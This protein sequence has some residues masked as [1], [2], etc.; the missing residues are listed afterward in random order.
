M[1]G[2]RGGECPALGRRGGLRDPPALSLALNTGACSAPYF[3]SGLFRGGSCI[4]GL[5]STFLSIICPNSQYT[6]LC[7]VLYGF[8]ACCC[9][10]RHLSRCKPCSQGPQ[11]L[12]CPDAVLLWKEKGG[13]R[14]RYS[15][16]SPCVPLMFITNHQF[17]DC[18]FSRI[19]RR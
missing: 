19:Q 12:V 13:I 2:V 15:I 17:M 8:F 6:W 14:L 7:L 18:P 10:R 4:F 16:R 11:V 5:S 9:W 1:H 3:C